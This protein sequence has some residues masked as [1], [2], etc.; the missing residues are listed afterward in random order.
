MKNNHV[1]GIIGGMGPDASVRM[2]RRMIEMSR[3]EFGARRNDDYPEILL[4]SVPVPEFFSSD[5]DREEALKIL[6][7]RVSDLSQLS[8]SCMALACNTAHVLLSELKKSSRVPFVSMIDEVGDEVSRRG[9]KRVGLLA[10][11]AT[12]ESGLYSEM[13]E[14]MKV[15][16]IVPNEKDIENLSELIRDVVAGKTKYKSRTLR[17]LADGLK[18]R[19]AEVIVLGCTELPLVFP[20][21]YDLP[22]IDSVEVLVRKLL[23]QYYLEDIKEEV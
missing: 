16:V 2:Y 13:F 11:P 20:E 21:N 19:G 6:S 14:S 12:I 3:E 5:K 23:L 8:V 1:I 4:H 15:G 10:S 9:Y 18:N 7:S 17:R 22:V